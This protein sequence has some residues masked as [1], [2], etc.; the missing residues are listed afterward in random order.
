[1]RIQ[2]RK[3]RKERSEEML[4]R[5]CAQWDS[6]KLRSAFSL[7]VSAAKP[8]DCA[9]QL[10]L[11]YFY[12]CGL[13]VKHNRNMA[14]HWYRRAWRN[15]LSSGANN[16]GTIF[17]DEGKPERA[18]AWFL[19][20]VAGGD[21]GANL[22]IAKLHMKEGWGDARASQCLNKVAKARPQI[23][24]EYEREQSIILLKKLSRRKA[25]R[26]NK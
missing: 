11:G 23:V 17:R 9:A 4:S 20:A 15:G 25:K 3:T 1:M 19:K 5:A 2:K 24:S 13:G 16:I 10:D 18:L 14:M 8:G 12:D 6:G 21:V 26:R 22:E 7:L